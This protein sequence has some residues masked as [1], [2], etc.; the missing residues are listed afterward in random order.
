MSPPVTFR[1]GDVYWDAWIVYR[2]LFRRSVATAAVVFAAVAVVRVLGDVSSSWGVGIA[3]GLLETALEWSAPVFVQGALVEIVRNVHAGRAPEPISRLF[4]EVRT[5]FLSLFWA[6]IVYGFGVLFGLLLLIVPGVIVAARWCLMAP[7]IMLEGEDAGNARDRSSLIVRGSTP[8]VATVLAIAYLVLAAP[9]P[10]AV[11]LYPL[12]DLE[13]NAV[14]FV[15][16]SITAPY[17]AHLLTVLYYR[18]LEPARPVVAPEVFG[19]RSVWEG[20]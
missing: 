10:L 16:N 9:L 1:L 15:W 13:W 19:W 4:S 20:R 2:L 18:F 17:N 12:G 3:P 5:R 6:S 7:L 11:L 14:W 8:G